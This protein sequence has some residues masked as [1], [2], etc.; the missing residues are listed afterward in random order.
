M[1]P[2]ERASIGQICCESDIAIES[3]VECVFLFLEAKYDY[4]SYIY[5]HSLK[6]NVHVER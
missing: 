1:I 5:S 3:C 4:I 6:S 2:L